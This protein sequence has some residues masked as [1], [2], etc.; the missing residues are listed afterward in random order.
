M[1]E[2]DARWNGRQWVSVDGLLAWNGRQSV[3]FGS[4]LPVAARIAIYAAIGLA[5]NF[6]IALVLVLFWGLQG[7]GWLANPPDVIGSVVQIALTLGGALC[8]FCTSWFLL[9]I[10]R[11]DWWLGAIFA[12]LWIAGG[13][14]LLGGFFVW[15]PRD[16]GTLVTGACLLLFAAVPAAG[17]IAGSRRLLSAS[18]R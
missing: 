16:V 14:A 8:A 9:R 11:R 7:P 18:A 2:P 17:S 12:W 5:V 10:D 13:V 1:N 6:P 4:N 3:R 15:Q